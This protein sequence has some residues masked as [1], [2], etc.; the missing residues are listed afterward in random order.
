MT[1]MRNTQIP[2]SSSHS[3]FNFLKLQAKPEIYREVPR[4]SIQKQATLLVLLMLEC[5]PMQAKVLL[6]TD[7]LSMSLSWQLI[8]LS[9]ID[10]QF[11][12]ELPR[13]GVFVY[14][15]NITPTCLVPS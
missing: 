15:V 10:V 2:N 7:G 9:G 3:G 5:V 4:V 13:E 1:P 6:Q 14:K 11:F 12:I 8:N